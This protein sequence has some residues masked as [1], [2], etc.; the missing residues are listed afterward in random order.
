M[1]YDEIKKRGDKIDKWGKEIEQL[2]ADRQKPGELVEEHLG[3]CGDDLI[4][5]TLKGH[6][7]IENLLEMN[8]CRLLAL[9]RLP[10]GKDNP[11]LEF[12]QKLK[13]I[14]A[15]V[16]AREP[17]PNADLFCAIAKLNKIRNDLAHKLMSQ[18]EIEGAVNSVIQSYQ[19]KTDLKLSLDQTTAMQLRICILKLC[20]FL[21]TVRVHFYK[22]DQREKE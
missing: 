21:D 8:L 11:D 5:I 12:S 22:L 3:S 2:I 16:I 4:L 6:L 20:R 9:D 10:E 18:E 17:S 13:L 19:S 14:Q 1:G 15:V 7:I